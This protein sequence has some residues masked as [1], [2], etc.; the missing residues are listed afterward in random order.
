MKREN[1]SLLAMRLRYL[2]KQR[3]MTQADVAKVL[4]LHRTSYTNYETDGSHPDP[5][6]LRVLA[7]LFE[8]PVDYLLG[9]TG[10]DDT[11]VLQ[12]NVTV[13]ALSP[14]EMELVTSFRQLTESQQQLLL[15]HEREFLSNKHEEK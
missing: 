11:D 10:E 1:L 15:L 4:N 13:V 12:D 14:E 6:S 9:K 8:V 2:R 7:D 3:G 5:I